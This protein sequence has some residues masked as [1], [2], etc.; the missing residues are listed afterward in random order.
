[1]GCVITGLTHH[2]WTIRMR[3]KQ[4]Q[5]AKTEGGLIW[6]NRVTREKKEDNGR[7]AVCNPCH[8]LMTSSGGLMCKKQ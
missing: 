6:A 1:M 4:D 5:T 7:G 2:E 8:L 3:V